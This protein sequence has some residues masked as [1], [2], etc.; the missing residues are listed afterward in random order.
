MFPQHSEHQKAAPAPSAVRQIGPYRTHA[1]LE[2][3]GFGAEY[4]ASKSQAAGPAALVRLLFLGGVASPRRKRL[5]RRLEEARRL[6]H[7]NLEPVLDVVDERGALAVVTERIA[8]VTLEDVFRRVPA[9]DAHAVAAIVAQVAAGVHALHDHT[10][11]RERALEW[12]HGHLSPRTILLA[13]DGRAVLS[14][15][16]LGELV[17]ATND[18]E[19]FSPEQARSGPLDRRSDV[20]ALG[21]VL[22]EGLTGSKPF[23]SVSLP[24]YMLSVLADEPKDPSELRP[25]LA[26]ELGRIATRCLTREPERRWASA[27][28]L[29]QALQTCPGFDMTASRERLS[30]LLSQHFASE[31]SR[32]EQL[33]QSGDPAEVSVARSPAMAPPHGERRFRP[34]IW[35]VIVAIALLIVAWVGVSR[36]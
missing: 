14:N 13:Y 28:E 9:L 34:L 16:G 11:R 29:A 27:R 17:S 18:F 7:P 36:G 1:L 22:Y 30:A 35:L 8:G 19:Y 26:P 5:K 4:L 10:D 23:S 21:L 24:D 20:F 32:D 3:R 2:N 12:V 15:V 31:R 25:D 33:A 6:S